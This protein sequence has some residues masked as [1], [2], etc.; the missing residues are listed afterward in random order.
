MVAARLANLLDG[1]RKDHAQG[2][3]IEAPTSQAEAA[4]RLNVGRLSVQRAAKLLR[5]GVPELIAIVDRGSLSVSRASAWL[6]YLRRSRSKSR[7]LLIP[8][9]RH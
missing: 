3:S 1:L 2:A 5:K 8:S 7:S 4:R 9:A 6:G